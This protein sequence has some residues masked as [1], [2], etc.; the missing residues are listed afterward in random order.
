[1]IGTLANMAVPVDYAN[2][3]Q[4]FAC[5]GLLELADRLW[6]GA[7]GWFE[8]N[9]PKPTFQIAASGATLQRLLETAKHLQFAA[10]S[11]N[12]SEQ[13]DN[14]ELEPIVVTVPIQLVLDWWS[15]SSIKTW[16]GRMEEKLILSAMLAAIQSEDPDPLN[17]AMP[18]VRDLMG[19]KREPFYFD[20]RRGY[21]GHALDS[22]FSPDKQ[23]MESE[24]FPAVEALCFI[25]LQ[26]ARPGLSTQARRLRYTV[27]TERLPANV[28]APVV[29]GLV[30]VRRSLMLAFSTV[31]RDDGR[32]Y[33]RY[34]RATPERS[35]YDRN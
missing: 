11:S 14:G 26:R 35:N 4:F 13:E 32:R 28:I 5:C 21:L 6:P 17:R 7:E 12:S 3:G 31:F 23:G 19:K 33:K 16:A 1:M 24:C 22:G 15:E 9:E 20:C 29:C 30:P 10:A 34:S 2:P 27:W 18:V 25:G 8:I